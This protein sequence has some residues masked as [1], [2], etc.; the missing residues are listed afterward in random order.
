MSSRHSSLAIA[1]LLLGIA[2]HAAAQTTGSENASVLSLGVAGIATPQPDRL[3]IAAPLANLTDRALSDIKIDDIE[4]ATAMVQTPLPL[5]V[6]TVRGRSSVTVQ[7]ELDSQSLPSGGRYELL[8]SGTYRDDEGAGR[9]FEV[10]TF[11]VLPPPSPDSG[12][13]GTTQVPS[14]KVEGGRYPHQPP[15]MG[16]ET[17]SGAPPVPTNPEAPGTPATSGT[18]VQPAPQ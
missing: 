18:D 14:Q 8:M 3:Y 12:E 2:T 10:R 9:R 1:S 17:N 5:T 15:R 13:F 7:V 6:G 4:L 11:I 16:A